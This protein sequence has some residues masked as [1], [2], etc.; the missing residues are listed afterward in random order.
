MGYLNSKHL[1]LQILEPGKAKI[2]LRPPSTLPG[3]NEMETP[4]HV[5]AS[6]PLPSQ[7]GGSTA[8]H[9]GEQG[10]G[11]ARPAHQVH[12]ASASPLSLGEGPSR[13]VGGDPEVG[14]S[15]LVCCLPQ[16]PFRL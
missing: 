9:G 4:M 2:D 1:F 8:Q 5:G 16:V 11:Q 14:A 12:A 10:G 3:V 13:A 6:C 15:P 7:A